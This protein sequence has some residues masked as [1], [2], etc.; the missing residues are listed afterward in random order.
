MASS[1]TFLFAPES[2]YG[3]TNNCLG[4]AARLLRRGHRVVFAAE[5]SWRGRLEPWG[6]EEELIELAAPTATP[7]DPGQFWKDYVGAIAPE[8]ARPTIEQLASVIRPIW[9]ELISGA[10]YAEDQLREVVA[11]VRPDVIIEDNVVG[12][13]AL[14]NARVPFVRVVSCNPLEVPSLE[15]APAFSGLGETDV[16]GFAR[17]RA[18]YRETH[19]EIWRDFDEWYRAR[20]GV[21][22]PE[23]EFIAR[24]DLN[25]YVYPRELDYPRELGPSWH[26]LES[27]VRETESPPE[28]PEGFANG[29]RRVIYFSLGS[30]GSADVTLMRRIVDALA[31]GPYDVMVSKGPRHEEIELAANM[32][33]AGFIPQTTLIPRADL[34]LTH[35][36][37]NTVTE[38]MHF[39]KPMLVLPLFWDQYD[40]AQRVEEC[41]FGR[42]LATYEVSA[43]DLRHAVADL[44]GDDALAE[45]ARAAGQRI[46]RADGLTRA[47]ALIEGAAR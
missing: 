18:A 47:A 14:A 30:L 12:F 27:S 6:I 4:I 25:L 3:P 5:S 2:A 8:F 39:G 32:W 17:F 1:R 44:L 24:G 11:R 34:V 35:G 13:P 9:E 19:E 16:A 21:G 43:S 42:R 41:G 37:N 22:L 15:L 26:R 28:L 36:G 23:L 38:S 20:A 31:E 7:Q 33:G 45:R 29:E 46:R 40:N 10:R